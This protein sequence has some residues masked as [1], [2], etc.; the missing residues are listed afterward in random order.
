M[1]TSFFEIKRAHG[2]FE[3]FLN[4]E[5]EGRRNELLIKR[6]ITIWDLAEECVLNGNFRHLQRNAE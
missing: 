3:L 4:K 2:Q 6:S 5:I 1:D